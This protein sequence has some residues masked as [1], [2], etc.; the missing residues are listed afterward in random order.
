MT[1][2][3]WISGSGR[4][5]TT[6]NI[7]C[8]YPSNIWSGPIFHKDNFKGIPLRNPALSFM[9]SSFSSV[10]G[11]PRI[12]NLWDICFKYFGTGLQKVLVIRNLNFHFI[13]IT[14]RATTTYV[15]EWRWAGVTFHSCPVSLAWLLLASG[16]SYFTVIFLSMAFG[17]GCVISLY[18]PLQPKA[19]GFVWCTQSHRLFPRAMDKQPVLV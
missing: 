9:S 8:N 13:E 2:F 3:T 4:N 19:L 18:K 12:L 11:E 5:E 1:L 7:P 16:Y 10:L 14:F 6:I 17:N 15:P